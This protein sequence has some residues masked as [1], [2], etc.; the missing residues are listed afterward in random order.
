MVM[1]KKSTRCEYVK[2][3]D[4]EDSPEMWNYIT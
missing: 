2:Q 4:G 1:K 3:E